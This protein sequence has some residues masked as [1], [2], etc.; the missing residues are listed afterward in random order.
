[1]AWTHSNW[2]G[3]VLPAAVVLDIRLPRLDGWQIL[4]ELKA[5]PL[6][7]AIPVIIAS[8]IDDRPRGL[9]LGADVYLRK[10]VR[11]EELLDAL[12][13]VGVSVDPNSGHSSSEAS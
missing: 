8:V 9:T 7:A 5:D 4:A 10:P 1:M 3:R 6:T 11:R 13:S 12:R 2:S